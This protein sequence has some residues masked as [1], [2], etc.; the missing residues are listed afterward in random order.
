MVEYGR[1][2]WFRKA[3]QLGFIAVTDANGE[4]TGEEIWFHENDEFGACDQQFSNELDRT[5]L[6]TIG[7]LVVFERTTGKNNR[8]KAHWARKDSWLQTSWRLAQKTSVVTGIVEFANTVDEK[9]HEEISKIIKSGTSAATL[10]QFQRWTAPL[11]ELYTEDVRLH[12]HENETYGYYL[13]IM[14]D[15]KWIDVKAIRPIP[16]PVHCT[17]C[18]DQGCEEC[19]PDYY[20]RGREEEDDYPSTVEIF[21]RARRGGLNSEQAL[22]AAALYPGDYM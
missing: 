8:P 2:K 21:Q 4:P 9:Y 10:E 20:A 11:L 18:E 7:T 12:E 14:Q 15:G 13:Q 17:N 22:E 3:R 1:I 5:V 6:P 16:E 19:I